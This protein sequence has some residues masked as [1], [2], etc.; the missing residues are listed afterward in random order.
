[1]NPSVSEA[2]AGES[3]YFL[4]YTGMKLPL[5]LISPIEAAEVRNRNTFFHALYDAQD[6]L[7]HCR[8]LVYGEVEMAHRYEYGADGRLCR[9]EVIDAEGEAT[10]LEF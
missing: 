9:A 4:S 8:K 10:V 2:P 5:Q 6:R 3:R 1:M 7:V